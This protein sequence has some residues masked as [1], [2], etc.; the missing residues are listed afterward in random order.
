MKEE[1]KRQTDGT[2]ENKKQ[3]GNYMPVLSLK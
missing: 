2:V 3:D 1:Q